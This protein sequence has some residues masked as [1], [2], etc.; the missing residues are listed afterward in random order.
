MWGK[1]SVTYRKKYINSLHRADGSGKLTG[2][3]TIKIT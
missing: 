1:I 3:R 2:I